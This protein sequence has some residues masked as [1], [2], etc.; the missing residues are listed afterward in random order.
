MKL[1]INTDNAVLD[2]PA[3]CNCCGEEFLSEDLHGYTLTNGAADLCDDCK[4]Y[5]VIARQN[6][7]LTGASLNDVKKEAL[8]DGMII[9]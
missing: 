5:V 7:R 3:E 4:F 2:N 8:S 1:T 9:Q 6:N